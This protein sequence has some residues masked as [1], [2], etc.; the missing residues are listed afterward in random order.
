MA[1]QMKANSHLELRVMQVSDNFVILAHLLSQEAE[2]S[3]KPYRPS[4]TYHKAIKTFDTFICP[5]RQLMRQ[6]PSQRAV[7]LAKSAAVAVFRKQG[8][9]FVYHFLF[10]KDVLPQSG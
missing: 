8:E 3:L 10:G 4:R 1:S 7:E 9:T 6:I 5:L 2:S